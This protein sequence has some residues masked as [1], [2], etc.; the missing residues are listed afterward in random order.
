[1]ARS[2]ETQPASANFR[3]YTSSGLGEALTPNFNRLLRIKAIFNSA[4]AGGIDDEKTGSFARARF[5]NTKDDPLG[6]GFQGLESENRA[7][8]TQRFYDLQKLT[9]GPHIVGSNHRGSSKH[10]RGRRRQGTRQ[11]SVGRH[12]AHQ[13]ADE[14]FPRDAN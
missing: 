5:H 7:Y 3:G 4:I 14:G 12:P 11:S 9:S 6:A 8:L 10:R 1:M 2:F 13:A